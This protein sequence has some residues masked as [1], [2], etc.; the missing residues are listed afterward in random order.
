MKKWHASNLCLIVVVSPSIT[1]DWDLRELAFDGQ[2]HA[3]LDV[4]SYQSAEIEYSL[5]LV[6]SLSDT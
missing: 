2:K 5:F 6:V 3:T 4:V 1:Y